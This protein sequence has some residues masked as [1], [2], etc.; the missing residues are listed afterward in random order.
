M[1]IFAEVDIRSKKDT[2]SIINDLR[3]F[4]SLQSDWVFDEEKSKSYSLAL[5]ESIGCVFTYS[6]DGQLHGIALSE[7]KAKHIQISNITPEKSCRISTKEYNEIA[8]AFYKTVKE[9][10][11]QK[12]KQLKLSISNINPELSEI[13]TAKIPRKAF[14]S[15][16]NNH[17][18]SYHP[19]DISRLNKFICAVARY[20]RKNINWEHVG[21]FLVEQHGW[22]MENVNTCLNRINIGLEVISEYKRY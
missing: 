21:K 2:L 15:Y 8:T 11:K 10:N 6:Y 13:I 14:E 1:Q 12:K 4:S 19:N 5:P 16:L 7:V 9:W 3:E 17:P 18:L 22:S 20:S